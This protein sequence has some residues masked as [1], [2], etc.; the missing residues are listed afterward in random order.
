MSIYASALDRVAE[1]LSRPPAQRMETETKEVASW[2]QR[3][4]K[5]FECVPVGVLMKL[6]EECGSEWRCANELIIRE[7]DI[8]TCMYILLSGSASVYQL[9]DLEEDVDDRLGGATSAAET[10][11]KGDA[12][13]PVITIGQRGSIVKDT[14]VLGR[15]V[16]LLRKF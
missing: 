12:S 10:S 9:G 13:A 6:V 7:G 1:I 14:T 8:G 11:E 5:A 16:G 4:V 3:K 15:C 2:L